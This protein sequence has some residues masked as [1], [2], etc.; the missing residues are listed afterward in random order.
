MGG[1]A[2][3]VSYGNEEGGSQ[4][5]KDSPHKDKNIQPQPG[6][7]S[8]VEETLYGFMRL[9]YR[10]GYEGKARSHS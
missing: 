7:L 8:S 10:G 5:G 2:L 4:S 1:Y 3:R 6:F 9:D